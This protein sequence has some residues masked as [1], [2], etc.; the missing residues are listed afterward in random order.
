MG[1]TY[2]TFVTDVPPV[3][4]RVYGAE[5]VKAHHYSDVLNSLVFAGTIVGMLSFGY[6][7]DRLGRKFGMVS[8]L[9][10]VYP[11]QIC[12]GL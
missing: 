1:Q 6:L 12:I 9:I 8:D 10:F 2:D 4:R 5:A 7:S 11:A 3:L